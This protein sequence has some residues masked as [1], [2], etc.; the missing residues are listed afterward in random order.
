M[1]IT[2]DDVGKVDAALQPLQEGFVA[3]GG[4]LAVESGG[5]TVVVR[6]VLT[7]ESCGDCIVGP[8][9]LRAIVTGRL[10]DAGITLPVDVVDPRG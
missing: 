7:D 6:L 2:K 8:D 4:S 10:A 1:T 5:D 3:D 9:I